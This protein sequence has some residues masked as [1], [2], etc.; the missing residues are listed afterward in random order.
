MIFVLN[1][2]LSS[3]STISYVALNTMRIIIVIIIGYYH[4]ALF[5]SE[6]FPC[7]LFVLYVILCI[8]EYKFI[9]FWNKAYHITVVWI[10][11][12]NREQ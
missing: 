2:K 10:L 1:S 7:V 12:I 3:V 9:L 6:Y 8:W 11:V 4:P 5:E